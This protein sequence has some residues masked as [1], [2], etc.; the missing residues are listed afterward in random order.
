M[1]RN[2]MPDEIRHRLDQGESLFLLDVREPWETEICAIPGSVNIPMGD[3]PDRVEEIPSDSTV[4]CICHHGARSLQVARFLDAKGIA[5]VENLSGGVESW[6]T[7][8]DPAMPR[9]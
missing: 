8:V 1:L 5:R 2:S 4:V 6:A 3:I 7:T 9:Y